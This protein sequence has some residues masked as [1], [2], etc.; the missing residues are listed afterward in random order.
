M[1]QGI[2]YSGIVDADPFAFIPPTVDER[3]A[4]NNLQLLN[5]NEFLAD[6]LPNQDLETLRAI[7]SQALDTPA[8]QAIIKRIDE[9]II[10][11]I[12]QVP[13]ENAQANG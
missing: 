12:S 13:V 10:A 9:L 4:M 5:N 6:P 2:E 7:Y 11:T 1:R 3:E 8:K